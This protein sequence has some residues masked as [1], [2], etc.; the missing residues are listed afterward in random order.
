MGT[1]TTSA[2]G[3]LGNVLIETQSTKSHCDP[4]L[5]Q[6]MARIDVGK[7]NLATQHALA[8]AVVWASNFENCISEM[9]FDGSE[10]DNLSPTD[11]AF[12]A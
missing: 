8:V 12:C 9:I 4:K 3:S 10:S 6:G 1:K 2:T 11:L 7:V 5:S